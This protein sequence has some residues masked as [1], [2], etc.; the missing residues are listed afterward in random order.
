MV[1]ATRTTVGVSH[2]YA[3]APGGCDLPKMPAKSLPTGGKTVA[4][5]FVKLF[6]IH[7]AA[8]IQILAMQCTSQATHAIH[9]RSWLT[10]SGVKPASS[11]PSC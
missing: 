1:G 4:H 10:S 5:A 3:L 11:Q 7:K 2:S 9:G 6:Y 8:E